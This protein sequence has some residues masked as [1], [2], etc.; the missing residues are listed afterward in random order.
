MDLREGMELELAVTRLA[1][2]GK[3]VA[4]VDGLVVFVDGGLPG[5]RVR[6]RI[7]RARKGFAEAVALETLSPS[8]QAVAPA[9]RHFG[10]CG[11]C[12]WQDLDY[13]AQLFWKREQVAETLARLG[14]L[15]EVTVPE[16]V[17]SPRLYAYRNKMEF[18]FAGNLHLGLYERRRPGRVLDVEE[19]WLMEPWA[20]AVVGF[21]R[22][23]CRETGLPAHDART[24]KGAWRHLVLRQSAA[25]GARLVHLITGPARG[26]G[27]IPHRLGQALMARFPEVTGFVHSIRRAPAAVAVGERQVL[28]L[29]EPRLE[30]T[31]GRV[32]LVVSPD[33]FLQTNTE[34][35]ARLYELVARAAGAAPEGTAWDLYCGGGG[36]ALT[37]ARQFGLVHGVEADARAIEDARDA[38]AQNGL[39]NCVFHVGDAAKAMADLA[40]ARPDTVVL[41]PPRAGAAP[42]VLAA[43]LA[44][45]P[46]RVVYVS[47]HPAT[48]ARDLKILSELYRVDWVAP[49]DL[50]PHTPHI[51]SVAA[52]TLR[53]ED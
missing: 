34:A 3:G 35:A 37:L 26:L 9:C 28:A 41:D 48:L 7:E 32:R 45:A 15:A 44:A 38:A 21:F 31:V 53:R 14:D 49:V 1:L 46:A 40:Q 29:G 24:G 4:R 2:G 39:G 30:E 33:A 23:A 8:P 13:P 50:F 43:I 10:V 22:E 51:E 52:L 25:T 20:A 12:A 17:A 19:C 47:C 42:E 36:I 16:T 11:G 18:A 5:A 6:A 27:D